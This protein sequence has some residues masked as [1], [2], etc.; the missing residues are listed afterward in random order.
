MEATPK[1]VE[2]SLPKK[3]R[4]RRV[5]GSVPQRKSRRIDGKNPKE[6][7]GLDEIRGRDVESLLRK[8][9]WGGRI[10]D[11]PTEWNYFPS[12]KYHFVSP[13]DRHRHK[14]SYFGRLNNVSDDEIH[15]DEEDTDNTTS[16]YHLIEVTSLQEC[17]NANLCCKSCSRDPGN[18]NCEMNNNIELKV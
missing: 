10:H 12:N 15:D 11:N 13:S 17:I 4:K 6:A 9:G 5:K 14:T 8:G 7:D 3:K 18:N 2:V 16:T 1:N